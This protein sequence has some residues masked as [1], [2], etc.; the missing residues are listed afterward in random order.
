MSVTHLKTI[1]Y[2]VTVLAG[3]DATEERKRF[4]VG[5]H[6]CRQRDGETVRQ[7]VKRAVRRAMRLAADQDVRVLLPG[8]PPGDVE[9]IADTA[10]AEVLY[11]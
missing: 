8:D 5:T 2:E 1:T 3:V 11:D 10:V 6:R 4:M 9:V 7:A